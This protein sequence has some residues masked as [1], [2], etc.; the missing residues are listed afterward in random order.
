MTD[1][2]SRKLTPLFLALSLGA[3]GADAVD[4]DLAEGEPLTDAEIAALEEGKADLAPAVRRALP[5]GARHLYFG[6]MDRAYLTEDVDSPEREDLAYRWFLAK[7]GNEFKV[8]GSVVD[9][10]GFP[11]AGVHVGYKLQR[12]Y[13]Y[14]RNY[15]WYVVA[16]GDGD[17]AAWRKYTPSRS[18]GT[19]V[20][21]LTMT[22]SPLPQQLDVGLSCRGG[23]QSCAPSLQPGESCG[24]D[25]RGPRRSCDE[26]LFCQYTLEAQ[27][28]HADAP[29]TCTIKPEICPRGI[30]YMP[31]CGCD[32]R[33]YDGGCGAAQAGV[34]VLRW[35]TCDVDVLGEWEGR[36]AQGSRYHYTF[37]ADGSFVSMYQ[38]ACLFATPP[39]GIRIA[40]NAGRYE[41]YTAG[42]IF[43]GYSDGPRNGQ[44]ATFSV[45]GAGQDQTLTGNDYGV[46]LTLGRQP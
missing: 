28:G 20:Y 9:A 44:T 10:E 22:A 18:G 38:P 33:T 2:L 1:L 21:L 4:E 16:S 42:E 31:M 35:G 41:A 40:A 30:R 13:R 25:T 29:G 23:T 14:G 26:G 19:G 5:A 45:S 43:L 3:C 39:C 24:G 12:L 36:T 46:D 6:N 17:G 7:A 27:C 32:G 8:G 15:R 37:N 34:S 11:V